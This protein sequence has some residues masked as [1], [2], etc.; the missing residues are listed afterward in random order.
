MRSDLHNMYG[1]AIS[2]I[3]VL[4]ISGLIS[5]ASTVPDHPENRARIATGGNQTT[6]REVED[7]PVV[8]NGKELRNTMSDKELLEV[9]ELN[10]SKAIVDKSKGPDGYSTTYSFGEQK[11]SIT[12][13]VV[14]GVNVMAFGGTIK[15]DW[16]LG[17]GTASR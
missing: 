14:T 9:L 7:T 16:N 8:V 3:A 12:H 6:S 15:G 10:I 5:C 4:F 13:S 11:V 1:I 17:G 2:L